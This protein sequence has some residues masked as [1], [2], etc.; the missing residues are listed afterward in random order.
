M[1]TSR[2]S[3]KRPILVEIGPRGFSRH[4]REIYTLR[5]I[6]SLLFFFA[7]LELGYSPHRWTDFHVKYT[8]RDVS[9]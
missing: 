3:Y 7:V 4:I 9:G 6:F 5:G 8:K 1:I 2:G